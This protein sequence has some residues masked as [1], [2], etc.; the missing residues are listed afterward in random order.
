[1]PESTHHRFF[2]SIVILSVLAISL[3]ILSIFVVILPRFEKT[4]MEGKKEMISE[5][6]N[7]VISLIDEYQDE[8]G[9][10]LIPPDSA[11]ALAAERISRIRYGDELKD[12]FWIID[13]HTRMIMHPYRPELIGTELHDYKDPNGKLLFVESV[14]VVSE[15]GEGFVYYMWQWKDDPTRIVPKLSYVKGY[16]PWGWI[17]GTGIYLE[18]VRIEIGMLKSRLLKIAILLS[19][20]LCTILAFIIRQS[21]RI[22]NR[23]KQAEKDLHLSREKYKTLVQASTE[24]TLMLAEDVFIFSNLRFSDLSGYDPMEVRNTSFD[25][26][27]DFKWKSLAKEFTD[28]KKSISRETILNC[29]DGS[30]KEVILSASRILYAEQTGYIIV[31]KEISKLMQFEKETEVLASELQ[32]SLLLMNQPLKNFSRK[33]KKCSSDTSIKDAALLMTRKNSKALFIHQEDQIIG[34]INNNDLKSRVLAANLNPER[35]VIEVMT[36]PLVTLPEDALLYEGLIVMKQRSLSYLAL[37]GPDRQINGIVGFEDI[38][39]MQLNMVGFLIREIEK[40]EEVEELAR[41]YRRLPVL[42]RALIESGSNTRNLTRIITSVADAIHRRLMELALEELGPA[43]CKYAFIVM[44]SLGRMEQT[45]AT[46]QDNAFILEVNPACGKTAANAY[47]LALGQKLNRDLNQ[48]GYRKCPGEIMAGNPKWN[49]DLRA[50]KGYFTHWIQE[51][52]PQ[53]ILNAAIFFDFRHIYGDI[54]LVDELREYVNLSSENYAVFFLHMAQSVAKMKPPK[55]DFRSE[56]AEVDLKTILIPV[57]SYIRLFS[58]REKLYE[59]NSLA[60]AELLLGNNIID[61]SVYEE[62]TQSFSYLTQLRIKIQARSIA[63][64]D[65]PGNSIQASQLDRIEVLILKKLFADIA[66][67]QTRLGSLFSGPE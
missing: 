1:V 43:P 42:T 52:N 36:S 55:S 25:S 51:S 11:R 21:L 50:W 3:F 61:R 45:L 15:A 33:I 35:K 56:G 17:V 64:N 13:E 18:D 16:Q 54:S 10:N 40:A 12:Y 58:I 49:K 22:E 8:A 32:T 26:L 38:G 7:S 20:I 27:F 9:N 34:M 14:H 5:L 41:H 44:G 47:F 39:E 60:R 65:P 4:I 37:T 63:Q 30:H 29:K 19:V 48:V 57:T 28:P 2:I 67:L 24:G 46:D 6:T 23:R 66:G 59:T 53:N 62:L 31:I